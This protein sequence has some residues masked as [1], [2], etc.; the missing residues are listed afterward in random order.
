[1]GTRKITVSVPEDLADEIK[2]E[3]A[4][5]RA[6]SV[7]ALVCEAVKDRLQE[8]RLDEVLAELR[9]EIGPPTREDR[10]WVR[11]V[12]GRSSSTRGR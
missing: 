6:D 4:C 7:S 1:M 8:D 5:G 12:L 3:V 2:E 9:R 10:E 11:S